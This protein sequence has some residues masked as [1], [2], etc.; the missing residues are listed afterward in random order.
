MLPFFQAAWHTTLELAPWLLLG[1]FVAGLMH[2]LLP[3]DFVRRQ[4]SGRAGVAKAVAL[5]VP[6]PLCSCGV[7]PVAVSLREQQASRGATVG[8]L[9][10]TPQTGVDSI[11]VSGAMLGWPFALF[12]VVAALVTGLIG[13]WVTDAV[14][15]KSNELPVTRPNSAAGAKH[16]GWRDL[17]EHAL[18]IL[19]SIWGWLVVGVLLSAAISTL[20]PNSVLTGLAAYGGLAAMAFALVVSLPLYV[21]ATASVPIAA[22]LVAG[23]LPPGA[24]LVF[25]MAGPATNAATIGAVK[26][27]LGGRGLTVYLSTIVVG[28]MAAG[29]LFDQVL[30]ASS[31]TEHLH[32][33]PATWWNVTSAVVLL[34]LIVWFAVT[35]LNRKL[36]SSR[37]IASDMDATTTTVPLVG[38]SCQNCVNKVESS[39]NRDPEVQ[40]A[41]VTL[42][43]PQA[44]V[45]GEV[46]RERIQEIVEAAGFGVGES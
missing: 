1:A 21:C 27:T 11:L 37:P 26:R 40:Q 36:L 28:S 14:E 45:A 25:L 15:P 18:E 20:V 35:D 44:V 43:P 4:L 30:S 22:A 2:V 9:I 39:L 16:R 7:I 13:G 23:G 31:M 41:R 38:L 12:K 32:E 24:A 10:S 8:F 29:L 33:H 19:Q 6:L 5:G 46:S 42:E 34:L 17:V 3:R